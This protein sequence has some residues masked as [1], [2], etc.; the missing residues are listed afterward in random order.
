M[1]PRAGLDVEAKRTTRTPS[2]NRS[3]VIQAAAYHFTP[4][5]PTVSELKTNRCKW[6]AISH[7]EFWDTDGFE[8]A[9]ER[10]NF[11]KYSNKI[12]KLHFSVHNRCD[13]KAKARYD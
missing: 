1:C 10:I 2:G 5:H 8:T 11:V 6:N 13:H 3:P 4:I 9:S 7:F 12:I